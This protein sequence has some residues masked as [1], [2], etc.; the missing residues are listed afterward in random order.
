MKKRIYRTPKAV[1]AR[2]TLEI[3]IAGDVIVSGAQLTATLYDWDTEEILLGD[4]MSDEGGV[5]GIPYY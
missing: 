4:N 2:V 1:T 3:G 5:V